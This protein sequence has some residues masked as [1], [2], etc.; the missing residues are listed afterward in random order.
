M[1][2][3]F[4]TTPIYY[5]NDKP[6]IGHAYT[7]ISCDILARYNKLK[8]NDV[9]FLTGTD[10]HGQKVE[11]AAKNIN[12]NPKIFTDRMSKNFKE[13]VQFLNCETND[14]IRTTELRHT[15]KVKDML[16]ILW[17]RN[18]IY[19]KEYQGL[20]SIS[21]ERFITDK[22]AEEGEFKQVK[23]LKDSDKT[24]KKNQSVDRK[25]QKE[26]RQ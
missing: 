25:K 12:E 8:K 21:E 5:V 17:D 23:T 10:E 16:K 2:N 18:L 4:I 22:E 14:F 9:F 7:T 19:E 15:D 13:L 6:H 20:Y 1:E 24:A 26:K 3:Y 11:K